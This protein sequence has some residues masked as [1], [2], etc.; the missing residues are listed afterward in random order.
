M[1]RP[2][3]PEALKLTGLPARPPALAV[4]VL[5]PVPAVGPRVQLV[6]VAM[7]EALVVT[8]AGP[9]GTTVPPPAVT[10]NVTA[11]PA[12]GLLPVSVTLTDG[13]ALT[14]VLTG[15][16]WLVTEL[17]EMIAAAP[18]VMVIVPDVAPVKPGAEK[19]RVR[20]PM[21]PVM[22]RLVKV[23]T[24]LALVVAVSVPPSVP[25]P[26]AMAAVTTTPAW[27]TGLLAPSRS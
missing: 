11:T 4:T 17:A 7:P 1:A 3:V 12:I 22:D 21:V 25:P 10:S 2:A 18:A 5:L 24:P 14:A 16:L 13:G 23:A 26:D 20:L 8:V 15:A 19:P 9:A 27:L 6:A